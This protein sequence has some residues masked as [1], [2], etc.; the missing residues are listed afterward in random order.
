MGL[1]RFVFA[2]VKSMI[3]MIDNYDSFT[4]NLVRYFE[5]LGEA[6]TVYRNDALTVPEVAELNPT[7]LLLSPGPGTPAEAGITLPLVRAYAGVLPILGICLGHQAV[8]MAFGAALVRAERLMHGKTS[9]VFHHGDGLF[10][11]LPCPIAAARYHSL[12][13]DPATIPADLAVT[14]WTDR[15]EVMALAHQRL[16]VYGLQFHPESILSECGHE[17]LHRFLLTPHPPPLPRK[18]GGRP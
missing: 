11:G 3:L 16:P 18:G 9:P 10:L 8:G 17:I 1:V 5:E 7:R 6:V 13:L 2:G 4:Y 12:I 14:A 15:G